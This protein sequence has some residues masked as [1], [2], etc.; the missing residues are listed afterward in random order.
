[1]GGK[2]FHAR[3]DGLQSAVGNDVFGRQAA[4]LV[5][6]LFLHTSGCVINDRQ[7]HAIICSGERGSRS[8]S[9]RSER[10]QAYDEANALHAYLRLAAHDGSF[11]SAGSWS[12]NLTSAH[13]PDSYKP[14][15]GL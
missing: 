6:H 12:V 5:A 2:S 3:S 11:L 10:S 9:E 4:P 15:A 7:R 13:L 8:C 14:M 1:M